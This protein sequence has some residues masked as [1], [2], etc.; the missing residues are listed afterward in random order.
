MKKKMIAALLVVVAVASVVLLVALKGNDG[1]DTAD[2][3]YEA[4]DM[5]GGIGEKIIGDTEKAKLVVYEYADYGCSHCAEWNRKMNE[6]IKQ[7]DGELALVFRYY[8]LGVVSNSPMVARAATAAQ[9]QGYFKEY[10][11]LL[12]NN[13]AEWVYAESG[14]ENILVSYFEKASDGKGNIEQFKTDIKSEAVRKRNNFETRMG[15]K[16][17]L[18]GTPHFRIDGEQVA[19]DKLEDEIAKRF[20][21]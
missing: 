6:L 15:Q 3:I 13:Q 5:T 9:L 16:V 11:D 2:K 21:R 19:V 8:D 1:V 14:L 17:G 12:F 18:K 4:S 20:A 7:Y 10:K